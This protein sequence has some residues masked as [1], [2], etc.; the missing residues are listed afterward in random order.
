MERANVLTQ[1]RGDNIPPGNEKELL[2]SSAHSFT[3]VAADWKL[4]I[5]NRFPDNFCKNVPENVQKIIIWCLNRS[6]RKRPLAQTL[7]SVSSPNFQ[8]MFNF[9]HVLFLDSL[10]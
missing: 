4:G 8:L 2:E 5:V 6:P 9:T 1:L 10:I 3:E 7:L